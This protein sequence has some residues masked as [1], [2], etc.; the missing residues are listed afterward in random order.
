MTF[1][2]VWERLWKGGDVVVSSGNRTGGERRRPP[3]RQGAP[4]YGCGK[5][6]ASEP[7][8][9][10]ETADRADHSEEGFGSWVLARSELVWKP[11]VYSSAYLALIAGAEV[12]VVQYL[13]SLPPS[14]A[15]VIV[16]LITFAVYA[17][18]RLV[19]LESDASSSPYRTAF[20]RQYR[21]PLYVLAALAYGLA[22]ALSALGG[23]AASALALLPG[24]AWVLYALNLK[25][26]VG[27]PF[28]RLKERLIVNSL[29]VAV[30]W[31]LTVVFLPLAFAG[32]ALT[33]A[34]GAIFVYFVLATFVNTE[35]ANVGDVESDREAGVAT[36]PTVLG[37]RR[38]RH[39]LSGVVLLTATGLG[40]AALDGHLT[41]RA[42]V[43][44]GV[45]LVC[46]TGVVAC[47]GRV[48]REVLLTV[49]A[50]CTRLPAFALLA[51]PV[52][53]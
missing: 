49:A 29:L 26:T 52:F 30:A 46:L 13:F 4:W 27:I 15:P 23:P 35:V 39:A 53:L 51:M 34:A 28:Q 47:L 18:D 17:N 41:G 36:L 32:R 20:V 48:E 10:L 50:E 21:G 38:T 42:A 3:P 24:I 1:R 11:L 19:D 25:L 22:V 33:P 44:L 6:M 12:L 45:S 9:W 5:P 43:A 2:S 31:S 16:G 7:Q 37:V 40:Y 8:Q 14:P